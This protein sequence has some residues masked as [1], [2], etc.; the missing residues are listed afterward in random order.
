MPE[1]SHR[2]RV[3]D[4]VVE[5]VTQRPSIDADRDEVR[6]RANRAV[7]ELMDA[8]VQTFTPLLAEN[9]VVSELHENSMT[10]REGA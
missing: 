10:D 2:D 4:E 6:T 5:K 8:P 7:D 3:V 9:T 1:R